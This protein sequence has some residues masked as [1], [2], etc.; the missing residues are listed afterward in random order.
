VNS[1]DNALKWALIHR[2]QCKNWNDYV[3]SLVGDFE[4]ITPYLPEKVTSILDIGCGLGGIDIL[5]K[6]RFPEAHLSLL[7]SDGSPQNFRGGF[8][9]EM[10]PFMKREETERFLSGNGVQIDRWLE[11][12]TR[13]TLAAD[14]IISLYSW[15]WHYPL[16]TYKVKG[17]VIADLRGKPKGKVIAELIV[18][19]KHKGN[20]CHFV[21]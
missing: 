18:N 15:G 7:D 20:R 16:E 14:L 10:L 19:G 6:Q 3:L 2:T 1:T 5:L 12:G 17:N 8:G 4:Q 9:E 21:A 11:V 13:E